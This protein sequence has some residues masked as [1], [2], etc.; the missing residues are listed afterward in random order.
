MAEQNK[1]HHQNDD[2]LG[3]PNS[4]HKSLSHK[5]EGEQTSGESERSPGGHR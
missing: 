5:K 4:K 2:Q 3:M 1:D